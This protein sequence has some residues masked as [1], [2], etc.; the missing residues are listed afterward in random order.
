MQQVNANKS[1]LTSINAI[2]QNVQCDSDPHF[3]LHR[4][5]N[6]PLHRQAIQLNV[7]GCEDQVLRLL[8][9][10]DVRLLDAPRP[11]P[12]LHLQLPDHQVAGTEEDRPRNQAEGKFPNEKLFRFERGGTDC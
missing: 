10:V 3:D 4:Q 11:P 6:E 12:L 5:L 2:K 9:S 1:K 7:S 8:S